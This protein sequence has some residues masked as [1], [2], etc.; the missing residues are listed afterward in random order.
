M[1]AIARMA[2]SAAKLPTVAGERAKHALLGAGVAIVGVERISDKAAV[3]WLVWLPSTKTA[4]AALG[5][6]LLLLIS[7]ANRE[8]H[9]RAWFIVQP[10]CEIITSI[11][12]Q[13]M[14]YEQAGGVVG[15]EPFGDRLVV[16]RRD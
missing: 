13:V 16:R 11:Q 6:G 9:A 10:C 4:R 12:D 5:T 1:P 2:M 14:P 3:T 7:K 8:A 15:A